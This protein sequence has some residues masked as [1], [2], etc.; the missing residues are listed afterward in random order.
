MKGIRSAQLDKS[1]SDAIWPVCPQ[2]QSYHGTTSPSGSTYW[3]WSSPRPVS[4]ARTTRHTPLA[5][6][7]STQDAGRYMSMERE[8]E[9]YTQSPKSAGAGG[10][11]QR[12]T[13]PRCVPVPE[14]NVR[15][16]AA[17]CAWAAAAPSASADV[18]A[19]GFNTTMYVASAIADQTRKTGLGAALFTTAASHS[20]STAD[21]L[22]RRC[23]LVAAGSAVRR[24]SH[25]RS[26][27]ARD[28]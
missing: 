9:T 17:P 12:T 22:G 20:Q 11:A 18:G 5:N 8:K 21:G 6:Q 24:A 25:G 23:L 15:T 4:A 26:T 3:L 13:K 1:I 28:M 19:D 16:T 27:L 7:Q 10:A 14:S 2:R